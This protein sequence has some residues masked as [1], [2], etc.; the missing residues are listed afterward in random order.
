MTA[1]SQGWGHPTWP[2]PSQCHHS[3]S[4][5]ICRKHLAEKLRMPKMMMR[6][7]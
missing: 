4:K 1:G 6:D 5:D 7:K 3:M 2:L